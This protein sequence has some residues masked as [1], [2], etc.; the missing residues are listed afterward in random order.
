MVTVTSITDEG[1]AWVSTERSCL[2]PDYSSYW[3][4]ETLRLESYTLQNPK[5]AA[6]T[7]HFN[8]SFTDLRACFESPALDVLLRDAYWGFCW[9][10]PLVSVLG[11]ACCPEL[12][13][14][15]IKLH[16]SLI[17]LQS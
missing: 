6:G 11:G 15:L 8:C 2:L 5:V 14:V 13:A 7:G 9:V 4:L 3:T 1:A 12:H 16:T 17:K 10:L